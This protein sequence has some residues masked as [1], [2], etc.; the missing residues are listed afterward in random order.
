MSE[1]VKSIIFFLYIANTP[2]SSELRVRSWEQNEDAYAHTN[3]YF[4]NKCSFSSKWM[5][6]LVALCV[7]L[8]VHMS[9]LDVSINLPGKIYSS[10]ITMQE[11]KTSNLS[12]QIFNTHITISFCFPTCVFSDQEHICFIFFAIIQG[13][14]IAISYIVQ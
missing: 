3:N 13:E 9:S 1:P 10:N 12:C 5:H 14:D 11:D 8:C 7:P 2:Y 4:V 6:P